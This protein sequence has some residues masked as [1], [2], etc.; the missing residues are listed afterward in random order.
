MEQCDACSSKGRVKGLWLYD[1]LNEFICCF[2]LFSE[3][4][5]NFFL[6]EFILFWKLNQIYWLF[7]IVYFYNRLFT[8]FQRRSHIPYAPKRSWHCRDAVVRSLSFVHDRCSIYILLRYILPFHNLKRPS[9]SQSRL[10]VFH[11][12]RGHYTNPDPHTVIFHC[13]ICFLGSNLPRRVLP[14]QPTFHT[15]QAAF[16]FRFQKPTY[17]PRPLVTGALS[18]ILIHS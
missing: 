16:T 14:S 9:L 6:I 18:G 12:R 15:V 2:I 17:T 5:Q 8:Q 11:S 7:I 4:N 3:S 13:V 1:F 10:S